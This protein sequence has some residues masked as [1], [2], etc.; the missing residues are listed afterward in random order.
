MR[1]VPT[2]SFD[3]PAKGLIQRFKCVDG[4]DSDRKCVIGKS[5]KGAYCDEKN[6]LHGGKIEA[7]QE[8]AVG[9]WKE[10][11]S[12]D[13]RKSRKVQGWENQFGFPWE[14][15]MYWNFTTGGNNFKFNFSK[16]IH[17]SISILSLKRCQS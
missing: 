17:L 6:I 14:I 4:V 15:G 2:D 5:C 11:M 9:P 12:E 3:S 16:Q 10:D 1:P 7:I 13:E 8:E